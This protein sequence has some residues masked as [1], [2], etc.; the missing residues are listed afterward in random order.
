MTISPKKAV[1]KELRGMKKCPRCGHP[2]R[3]HQHQLPEFHRITQ[4]ASADRVCQH[5][6]PV[7]GEA[8]VFRP[9]GCIVAAEDCVRIGNQ[10]MIRVN[11]PR[12]SQ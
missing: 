12:H 3:E 2:A 1:E 10:V 5:A 11:V 4:E 7:E 9:C 8:G 6:V